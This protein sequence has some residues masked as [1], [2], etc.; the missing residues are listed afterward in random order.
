VVKGKYQPLYHRERDTVSIVQEIWWA[1]GPVSTDTENLHTP[2]LE[3]R[4]VQPVAS[5]YTNYAILAAK[6]CIKQGTNFN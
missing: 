4:T 3:P 1:S 2:S 5:H 6:E